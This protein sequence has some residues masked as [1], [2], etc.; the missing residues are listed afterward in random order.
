MPV[1]IGI[2]IQSGV[3]YEWLAGTSR[4][5]IAEIYN[6]STGGVTN[7]INEWR[8]RIGGYIAD[9]LRELALSLKKA[10]LTPFQCSMGFRV[11]KIMQRLGITEE[12]FESFMTDIYNRCQRLEVGPDQIENYLKEIIKLSKIVFPSEIPNYLQTQKKEIENLQEKNEN[13]QEKIS[14]SNIQ[15][16]ILE[17]KLDSLI[18][19]SNISRE[20]IAWYTNSQQE[21]Q[22]ANL[23]IDDIS[24]F[25]QCLNILR[26][27]GYDVNKI[28]S[29]FAE[30]KNIDDLQAFQQTTTELHQS[31]LEKL[32]YEERLLHEQINL[33]RLNLSQ[34]KQLESMGFSLKEFKIMYNKINEIAREHNIDYG[35]AIEKFLN[36]LD[37]YD[38]FLTL[39]DKVEILKQE[40]SLLN[41]QITNQRMTIYSQQYIGSALQNLLKMG[42]SETDVLEINSILSSYGFDYDNINKDVLNKQSLITDLYKYRNIK[43]AIR[44]YEIKRGEL[45]SRIMELENQKANLQYFLNFLMMIL[46]KFEDLQLLIQKSLE[47][48]QIIFI[49]LL[50]NSFLN[51]DENLS[52]KN[53]DPNKVKDQNENNDNQDQ[54]NEIDHKEVRQ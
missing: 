48:P 37:N 11:A 40:I 5:K 41:T 47:K 4:D 3:I 6:I 46:Y 10:K 15:K 51:E 7:I 52:E 19:K 43:L 42:L 8:N 20:A 16:T 12:Q 22:N 25:S 33:H 21:L 34:I 24:L 50:Y 36:D 49:C 29:K 13:L 23:S 38:D 44:D 39:K 2:D 27:Q 28:L 30:V 35:I 17:R 1:R 9:D 18:D 32:M 14:E 45:T 31:N 26:S 54:N 53:D